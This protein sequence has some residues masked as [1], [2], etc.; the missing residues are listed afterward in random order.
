MIRFKKSSRCDTASCV[1]VGAHFRKST[2][3]HTA[4]CVEVGIQDNTQVMIRDSK[5]PGT[6][7]VL[8]VSSAAW[9]SFVGVLG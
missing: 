8:T 6:S 9:T 7:P 5:L 2:R 3:S 4:E 1:E